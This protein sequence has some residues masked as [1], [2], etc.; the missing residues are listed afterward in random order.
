[1]GEYITE[2]IFPFVE[3]HLYH[4]IIFFNNNAIYNKIDN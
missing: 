2:D 1:M 4:V 3:L